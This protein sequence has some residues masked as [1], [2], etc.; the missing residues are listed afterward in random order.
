MKIYSFEKDYSVCDAPTSL[1]ARGRPARMYLNVNFSV[2]IHLS[3][4]WYV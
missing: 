1:C 3:L 2:K 4:W